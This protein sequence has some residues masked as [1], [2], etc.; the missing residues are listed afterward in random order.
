MCWSRVVNQQVTL[1]LDMIVPVPIQQFWKNLPKKT[2]KLNTKQSF[3]EATA[4]H[5]PGA[6][7]S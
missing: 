1:L 7:D 6:A 2:F 4:W 5:G 3:A